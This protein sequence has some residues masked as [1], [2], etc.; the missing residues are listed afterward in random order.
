MLFVT[1]WELN[2]NMS[3]A[4]RLALAQKLTSSG[5]WPGK[6]VEILRWD[7][8][9]DGWG[10]TLFQAETAAAVEQN[11]DLWRAAGAGMFKVTKTAPATPVQEVMARMIE[12]VKTLGAR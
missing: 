7:M 1:Y 3:V 5:L 2:E 11:L 12:A 10:I 4:D 8:T 9:P 6:E